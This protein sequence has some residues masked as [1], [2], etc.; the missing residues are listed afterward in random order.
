VLNRLL[1]SPSTL[2]N[3]PAS[4]AWHFQAVAVQESALCPAAYP[5]TSPT[6]EES[7]LSLD[8]GKENASCQSQS[9]PGRLHLPAELQALRADLQCA[10]QAQRAAEAELQ[11]SQSQAAAAGAECEALRHEVSATRGTIQQLQRFGSQAMAAL[12]LAQQKQTGIDSTTGKLDELVASGCA[13][14]ADSLE[15]LASKINVHCS[16]ADSAFANISSDSNA[17]IAELERE[18]VDRLH[19]L[20]DAKQQHCAVAEKLGTEEALRQELE[21]QLAAEVNNGVRL[22]QQLIYMQTQ[23]AGTEQ[24]LLLARKQMRTLELRSEAMAEEHAE[25]QKQVQGLQQQ[26]TAAAETHA[27]T[28]AELQQVQEELASKKQACKRLDLD[29]QC[30]E[31]SAERARQQ[32]KDELNAMQIHNTRL[33]G[34]LAAADTALGRARQNSSAAQERV[35][36]LQQQ[37]SDLQAQITQ[38]QGD[39]HQAVTQGA[40][41]ISSL[42]RQLAVAHSACTEGEQQAVSLSRRLAEVQEERSALQQQLDGTRKCAASA[43]ETAKQQLEVAHAKLHAE[44]EEQMT[45]VDVRCHHANHCCMYSISA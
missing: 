12:T 14:L 10:R 33:Q 17:Q 31:E 6:L 5:L 16:T 1:F 20:A 8:E 9:S 26:L 18:R 21:E 29:G 19:A 23:L 11:A 15:E 42:E 25:L 7:E 43:A 27:G 13:H 38:L 34:E 2:A 40:D 3:T 35:A 39:A 22:Q 45:L 41:Q 44:A 30:N 37:V 36:A 24:E 28:L 4:P 32:L